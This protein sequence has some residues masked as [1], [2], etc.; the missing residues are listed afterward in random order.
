[1]RFHIVSVF[2][3]AFLLA[4][5]APDKPLPDNPENRLSM[6]KV[7]IE[8]Y[9]TQSYAG[10]VIARI[11]NATG[12]EVADAARSLIKNNLS[13]ET[14]EQQRLDLLVEHFTAAE[15]KLLAELAS[16]N[17][18]RTLLEKLPLF[19]QEITDLFNPFVVRTMSNNTE[20]IQLEGE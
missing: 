7:V 19:D 11:T 9:P 13:T 17:S 14:I 15:L 3:V 6:A 5:D 10:S 20:T 4:C 8:A 1:M 16:K 2:V 12:P 18:G